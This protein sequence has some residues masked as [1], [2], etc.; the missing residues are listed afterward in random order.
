MSGL[1]QKADTS[2]WPWDRGTVMEAGG[3]RCGGKAQSL[4]QAGMA[5]QRGCGYTPRNRARERPT[6]GW[7]ATGKW[8]PKAGHHG[9]EPLA[10]PRD[11]SGGH[12]PDWALQTP[13][14]SGVLTPTSW[15]REAAKTAAVPQPQLSRAWA[16]R[17][18]LRGHP[19]YRRASCC[20]VLPASPGNQHF[21]YPVPLPS[22]ET[23]CS[24]GMDSDPV[25]PQ[26]LSC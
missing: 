14:L 26:G 11:Q 24:Q 10:T 2:V 18:S 16:F 19:L 17:E 5:I 25:W 15:C 9:T 22:W 4:G 23:G 20:S 13:R 6:G 12:P 21:S 7:D 3:L 8:P 1:V